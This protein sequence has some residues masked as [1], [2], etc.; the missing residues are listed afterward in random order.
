[1]LRLLHSLS[2]AKHKVLLKEPA[3]K[4]IAKTDSFRLNAKFTDR[5]R[6]VKVGIASEAQLR[7]APLHRLHA[8]LLNGCLQCAGASLIP[9]IGYFVSSTVAVCHVL[10]FPCLATLALVRSILVRPDDMYTSCKYYC[11]YF[12]S[13]SGCKCIVL[14]PKNLIITAGSRSKWSCCHLRMSADRFAVVP[15][16]SLMLN[17]NGLADPPSTCG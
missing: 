16:Q 10:V 9:V 1:M 4:T 13:E 5:M 14:P 11:R 3:G 15:F 6:R 17:F 7:H 12:I 8:W 2:C